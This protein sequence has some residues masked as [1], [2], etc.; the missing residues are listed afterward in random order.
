MADHW[1]ALTIRQPWC[2]AITHDAAAPRHHKPVENRT[3]PT[4]Y[5]GPLWL[6]AGARSRWDPAGA[7]SPLVQAAWAAHLIG[8]GRAQESTDYPGL[9]RSTLLMDFGAVVALAQLAGCH[10]ASA[11]GRDGRLC[12]RW[13]VPGQFHF[14]LRELRRLA[15]PVPVYGSRKLWALSWD[16]DAAAR[17]QLA[18][19]DAAR[20]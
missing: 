3:W 4:R 11:C 15:E 18:G 17:A 9:R 6:T 1:P 16:A 12:S 14:V 13:A 10:H 5:R 8:Q 7:A 19:T 2:W 20:A